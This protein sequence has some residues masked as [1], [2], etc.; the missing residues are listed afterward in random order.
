[1]PE[2]TTY[3]I[4]SFNCIYIY[5]GERQFNF[6]KLLMSV[7]NNLHTRETVCWANEFPRVLA[8]N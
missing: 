4:V 7:P 6:G 1:M 5:N 2:N 3:T 8:I